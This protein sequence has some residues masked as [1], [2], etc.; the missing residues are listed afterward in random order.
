MLY[1]TLIKG[2]TKAKK[3]PD[4]LKIL[5]IMKNSPSGAKPNLITYNT[6]LDACAKCFF[7]FIFFL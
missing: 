2:F 3:L 4:A 1:T 5:E 7:F 6:I